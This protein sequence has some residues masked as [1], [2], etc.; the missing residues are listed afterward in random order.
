MLTDYPAI[1]S[2]HQTRIADRL[3][4][5]S[6]VSSYNLL[7]NAGTA[8]FNHIRADLSPRQRILVA[9]GVGNNGGDGLVVARLMQ[10]DGLNVS[11]ALCGKLEAVTGDARRALE[12]LQGEVFGMRDVDPQQYDIIVD[13]ILGSGLNRPLD[14]ELAEFIGEIN[15]SAATTISIDTPSGVNGDT[16]E[17]RGCAVRANKTVTFFLKKPGHLLFPG[18]A[19]CG[20]TTVVQIGIVDSALDRIRPTI[21]ENRPMLWDQRLPTPGWH[22]HK[23]TRGH[24]VVLSGGMTTTGA[25]RLAGKAALRTGSGLVTLAGP[26]ESASVLATH[27]TA[28][29]LQIVDS[30]AAFK[31]FLKDD[32]I[33]AVLLGPGLGVS[34]RT[35]ELVQVALEKAPAVVL[36]ADA[37]TSFEADPNMLFQSIASAPGQV[38]L[39]PH[40]GEFQRLFGDEE[41]AVK[42]LNSGAKTSLAREAAK[43]SHSI[44]VYKGPDTVIASPAGDIVINTSAP[45]WLATAG[46]GDV[47][48]GTVCGWLAQGVDSF[49]AACAAV[50][51][52]GKVAGAYG[53]GLIASDI[54]DLY[55]A[56]MRT[57]FK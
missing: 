30:P 24:S 25:A 40:H 18:R 54:A 29:L 55:P 45:P 8:V 13:S 51:M 1:L 57:W 38:V 50:W 17:I 42:Q 16:G 35:R 20:I 41:P 11:V 53:P 33:T 31:Q 12:S 32:R 26:A 19:M 3:T 6:G 39:T 56:L 46:S 43:R 52:H 47:L 7:T 49:D 34:H 15:R 48:A 2:V 36:D 14:G 4:I 37:L 21:F 27:L 44:V 23:Y 5:E 10:D 22:S 28:E 9:C